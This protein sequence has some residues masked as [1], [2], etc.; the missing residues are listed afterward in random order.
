[1]KKS[2]I[3]SLAVIAG[4]ATLATF[5]LGGAGKFGDV[6]VNADEPEPTEY[7]VTFGWEEPTTVKD[8][9]SNYVFSTTTAA[10]NKVGV[11]GHNDESERF[12]FHKRIFTELYL[13][14]F[15]SALASADAYGFGHITG[16]VISFKGGSVV[17]Q[18][19]FDEDEVFFA[20]E[21]GK[22]YEGLSITPS[23]DLPGF[24]VNGEDI[25]TVTSLTIWY[26]C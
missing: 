3:A 22:E 7:S 13:Y 12:Y 15:E 1:M 4:A 26:S 6:R 23:S 9:N 21:S 19:G 17:F 10:G 24:M 2:I 18:S 5:A 14:E 16:F 8:V 25:V 20:V 11:V